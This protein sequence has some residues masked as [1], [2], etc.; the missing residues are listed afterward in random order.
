MSAVNVNK[1]ESYPKGVTFLAVLQ[2]YKCPCCGGAIEFNSDAQKMKCPYCGSEFDVETLISYDDELKNDCDDNMEWE[3]HAG[4]EWQEGEA[5]N[6]NVYV[7]NSCGGE[8]IG[9]ETTAATSCPYCGNPVVMM[10]QFKGELKPDYVI[11]FKL[12]KNDALEALKKHYSGKPLLPK[13]FKVQNHIDEIKGVYVPVWHFD[14]D[15][16]G[17]ARYKATRTRFWS[18]SSYN[19]RETSY[20]S[21]TRAGNISFERV[22]VDG[23]SKMDDALM[24]SVEPYDFSGVVDFQ[25]AYLAG[26]LADKYDVSSEESVVRA[27]ERIK[28]ST[29]DALRNTV[30]GYTTVV[31]EASH[32]N[33]KNGVAKYALYPVWLLNTSWRGEKYFFAMNGQTGKFAGDLPLDKGAYWRWFFGIFGIAGVLT[34]AAQ[35]LFSMM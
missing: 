8:I 33:L 20:F 22:P 17:N 1:G 6:L 23:S 21:V 3:T 15:A 27:N 28:K 2:E 12:D 5:D 25:T 19:Y 11:P 10:G 24:E 14:A 35:F 31:T 7:C 32:V 18:D 16:D 26:Y 9:D 4:G 13:V 34:F 29:E 30:T